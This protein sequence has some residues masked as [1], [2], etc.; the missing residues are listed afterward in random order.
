MADNYNYTYHKVIGDQIQVCHGTMAEIIADDI[1]HIKKK[2]NQTSRSTLKT[3]RAMNNN[4]TSNNSNL[5]ASSI[6]YHDKVSTPSKISTNAHT[7]VSTSQ[8]AKTSTATPMNMSNT[9][10]TKLA[11]NIQYSCTAK[12]VEV[13][14]KTSACD[15]LVVDENE[16]DE[17]MI[18]NV[19][20]K[21]PYVITPDSSKRKMS[22]P[23]TK[24][25]K[26]KP[27]PV[28]STNNAMLSSSSNCFFCTGVEC[29]EKKYGNY[30]EQ[31]CIEFLKGRNKREVLRSTLFGVYQNN[32]SCILNWET[33]KSKET[34]VFNTGISPVPECMM[35]GSYTRCLINYQKN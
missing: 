21:V 7:K 33:N 11:P 26:R 4:S 5:N 35:N 2:H 8:L 28:K 22:C 17:C 3:P 31:V 1:Y 13:T 34:T 19:I 29:H 23:I 20:Q 9:V 32:Y 18:T 27:P 6:Q 16:S 25:V 10:A 15:I 14:N 12:G 24:K 30:C